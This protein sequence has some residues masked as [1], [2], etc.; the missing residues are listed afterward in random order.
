MD[1]NEDEEDEGDD[2]GGDEDGDDGRTNATEEA[3][4]RV[5]A[6]RR[7]M[8]FASKASSSRGGNAK[9]IVRERVSLTSR[10]DRSDDGERVEVN[11][12]STIVDEDDGEEA[13]RRERVRAELTEPRAR[14]RKKQ[15]ATRRR[16]SARDDDDEDD[17]RDFFGDDAE[18]RKETELVWVLER[19]GE[20]W[21]EEILPTIKAERRLVEQAPLK[22]LS[23][24]EAIL[25][26]RFNLSEDDAVAVLSAAAA[27][28]VTKKGRALVDKRRLRLAQEN[29]GPCTAAMIEAGATDAD[30]AK[31]VVEI[32]QVLAVIPGAS[33]WNS[34][35][36]EYVVR[37]N[38]QAGG[39]KGEIRLKA[40]LTGRP[41]LKSADPIREWVFE[42]R[43]RRATG[44]LSQEQNYLLDVA[45]FDK[46]VYV[47][48]LQQKLKAT[49]ETSF[50]ELVEF[51][52][53]TGH[54]N[55]QEER[56]N[57]GLGAWLEKQREAYRQGML[58]K[59]REER[60]RRLGIA[61]D[62]MEIVPKRI[63]SI[64]DV[65][66][67]PVELKM[68]TTSFAETAIELREFLDE[69][70]DAAEPEISS[71]LGVWLM[72]VRKQARDDKLTQQEKDILRVHNIDSTYVPES[73]I[74]MLNMYANLRARRSSYL[75][76]DID[77]VK[78]WQREQL[79]SVKK[80]DGSLSEVQMSRLRHVGM[81]GSISGF[82]ASAINRDKMEIELR[83]QEW[84]ER[85][86][87]RKA[88]LA[89]FDEQE[90][91]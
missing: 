19:R 52:I 33:K 46:G 14:T 91:E 73:W 9:A 30:V 74:A 71:P 22:A 51:Q 84:A 67:E 6:E 68:P 78:T 3:Y 64:R 28:R 23:A 82:A 16:R 55:P 43:E 35:F 54:I 70:G 50:D 12:R 80:N 79:D 83:R 65:T 63:T 61:F 66:V 47:T 11:A 7:E 34:C 75:G 37:T 77:R 25:V 48:V 49:W 45:G 13:K 76:V 15:L 59:T 40:R 89:S 31:I 56:V 18:E 36:I 58:D 26:E 17:L 41:R 57:G 4:R 10:K 90:Q 69:A 81:I 53:E 39:A 27:W 60:L 72:R 32:P 1:V 21:G 87:V 38:A 24:G 29:V 2:E 8:M 88:K 44:E 62:N 5:I 85:V 86:A 20:G 42:Q